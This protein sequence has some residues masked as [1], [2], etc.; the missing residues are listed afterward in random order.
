MRKCLYFLFFVWFSFTLVSQVEASEIKVRFDGKELDLN[1]SPIIKN[2][3]T[4]VPIRNIF[5]AFNAKVEWDP[6]KQMITAAK[7]EKKLWLIIDSNVA[8]INDEIVE[9]TAPAKIVNGNTLVPLRFISESYDSTVVWNGTDNT[10]NISPSS[11]TIEKQELPTKKD[12]K[13]KIK[14]LV[15]GKY[16][17]LAL[18]EDGTLTAWGSNYSG[19]FGDGTKKNRLYIESV[20]NEKN[21]MDVA[22]GFDHVAYI[23]KDGTLWTGGFNDVGQLGDGSISTFGDVKQ[24]GN[25]KDWV[26]VSAKYGHTAAIKK[27]G[28]LWT[29][30]FNNAGQLGDGTITNRKRPVKV[31]GRNWKS[32]SAGN[33]HTAA[34]KDDGT[35][36]TWGGRWRRK[37]RIK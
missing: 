9:L 30:G 3:T 34:L 6:K 1:T 27:D 22:S 5:E 20:R 12:N 28:T 37:I 10:I 26:S 11:S 21:W 32:V 13:S 18:R 7:A 29:W 16:Y 15:T 25:S 8:N 31:E 14:K 17:S 2:G 35:L 4:L 24:I 33:F 19:I 36:W 23:R